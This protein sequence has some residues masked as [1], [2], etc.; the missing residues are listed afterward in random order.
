MIDPTF[1]NIITFVLSFKMVVMIS[2]KIFMLSYITS[3]L[4]DNK[5]FFDKPV[6][7]KQEEYEKLVKMSRSDDY[8]TGNLLDYLHHQNYYKLTII[9]LSRQVNTNVPQQI[10][11][12]GKLVQADGATIFFINEKLQKTILIFF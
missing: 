10:N 7:N 3:A 12:K 2:G 6:K 5:L 8:T 11:F 4:I 9:D 1:R